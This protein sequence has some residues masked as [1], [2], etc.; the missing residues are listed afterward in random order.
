MYHIRREDMI[1]LFK[2]VDFPE[3]GL[4][5]SPMRGSRGILR[6]RDQEMRIE[7]SDL[8]VAIMLRAKVS[9]YGRPGAHAALTILPN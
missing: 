6:R 1:H 2:V 9:R 7:Q 3:D 5:T 8:V 4:P